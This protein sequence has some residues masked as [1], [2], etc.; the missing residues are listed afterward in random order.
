MSHCRCRLW[1]PQPGAG[2]V[3]QAPLSVNEL[4]GLQASAATLRKAQASLEL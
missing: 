1:C 3:L 4:L 2:E